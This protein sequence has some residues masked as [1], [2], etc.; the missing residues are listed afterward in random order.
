MTLRNW[1]GTWTRSRLLNPLRHPGYA[2][3]L[4]SHK[5][6][7]WLSPVFVVSALISS[8]TLVI[9]SP[10]LFTLAA[11]APIAGLFLLAGAGYVAPRFG[12][13]IP[14]AGTAFGFLLAN[15]AFLV[16][17]IRAM[18]GHRIRQYQRV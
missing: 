16:G 17:I 13:R 10:S 7:R 4:W 15:G 11:A 14:G 8:V 6:L 3:A 2:F 18:S 12:L 1:Q 9:V 5:L